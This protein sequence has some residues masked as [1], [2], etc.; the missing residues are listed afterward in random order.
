MD[1]AGVYR[2]GSR[3]ARTLGWSEKPRKRNYAFFGRYL[4][5]E[6]KTHRGQNT[7]TL[8]AL[9]PAFAWIALGYK[10]GYL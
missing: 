5:K 3:Y 2:K 4:P 9:S 1:K 7:H 6:K 10:K 8:R